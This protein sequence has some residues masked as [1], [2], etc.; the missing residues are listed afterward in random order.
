MNLPSYPMLDPE[1]C[2]RELTTAQAAEVAEIAE[3]KLRGWIRVGIIAP[4]RRT[5]GGHMRWGVDDVER[6]FVLRILNEGGVS[7]Q[8]LHRMSDCVAILAAIVADS[9]IVELRTRALFDDARI[10]FS[11]DD[12][13]APDPDVPRE[14]VDTKPAK[15]V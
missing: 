6:L 10:R 5:S 2:D 12:L 13:L 4:G 9:D 3:R 7:V 15:G 8:R 11:V 14:T 1:D